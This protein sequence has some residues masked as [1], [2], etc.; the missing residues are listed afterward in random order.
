MKEELILFSK[1]LKRN[2]ASGC[3]RLE[4]VLRDSV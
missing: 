2:K 4:E 1:T 3:R